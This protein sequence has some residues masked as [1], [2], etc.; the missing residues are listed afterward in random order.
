MSLSAYLFGNFTQHFVQPEYL[1]IAQTYINYSLLVTS[2]KAVYFTGRNVLD[3]F[4]L[5][6]ILVNYFP[7]FKFHFETYYGPQTCFTFFPR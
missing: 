6:K 4:S 1:A 2:T 5:K 3:I 7:S